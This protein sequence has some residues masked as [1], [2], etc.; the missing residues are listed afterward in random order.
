MQWWRCPR[1]TLPASIYCLYGV[2][3]E[4]KGLHIILS[5]ELSVGRRP[6][7][8]AAEFFYVT[9]WITGN[10]GVNN[11]IHTV[12]HVFCQGLLLFGARPH[13]HQRQSVTAL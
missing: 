11:H 8:V 4:A 7:A 6:R 9:L 13:A 1:R 10:G 3:Y 5:S 2:Y 12:T